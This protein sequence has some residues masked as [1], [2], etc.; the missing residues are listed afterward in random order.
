MGLGIPGAAPDI[1]VATYPGRTIGKYDPTLQPP[2]NT[3]QSEINQVATNAVKFGV[4]STL[5]VVRFINNRTTLGIAQGLI[6]PLAPNAPGPVVNP[7]ATFP[8]VQP[9]PTTTLTPDQRRAKAIFDE[10]DIATF[11]LKPNAILDAARAANEIN[12]ALFGQVA[13]PITLVL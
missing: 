13:P 11:M 9:L 3:T 7:P 12:L 8:V 6:V 10:T 5:A 1:V 4:D 2:V